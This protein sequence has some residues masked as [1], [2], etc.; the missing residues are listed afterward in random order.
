MQVT[1]NNRGKPSIKLTARQH[2][3]LARM[4][5]FLDTCGGL[6]AYRDSAQTARVAL[7]VLV[8][9]ITDTEELVDDEK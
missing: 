7:E 9:E 8:R 2:D 1:L 6:T 3:L 4:Y 5:E